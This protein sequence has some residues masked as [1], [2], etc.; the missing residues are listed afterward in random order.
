MNSV[1]FFERT[2]EDNSLSTMFLVCVFH[3]DTV[4][5]IFCHISPSLALAGVKLNNSFMS[6]KCLRLKIYTFYVGFF[7]TQIN[8]YVLEFLLLDFTDFSNIYYLAV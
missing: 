6:R 4:H 3:E 1:F 2:W 8:L 7:P 5:F